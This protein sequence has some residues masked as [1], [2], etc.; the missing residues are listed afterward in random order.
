VIA[1]GDRDSFQLASDNTKILYPVRAG[2]M[3]RI[4]PEEVLKRYGVDPKQVRDF[5]ALRGDPSDK[6]PGPQELGQK[7][8][9]TCCGATG[10]WRASLMPVA[11]PPKR[12]CFG[13]TGRSPP[14]MRQRRCPLS[15]TRR[16]HGPSHRS[17]R[18]GGD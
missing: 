10:R 17:W 2:E 13:S 3:A 9:L 8:L 15:P 12:R 11:S 16:R 5:I 1:S 14:W 6:L 4:G 7:A 18:E